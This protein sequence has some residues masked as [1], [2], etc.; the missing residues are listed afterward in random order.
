MVFSSELPDVQIIITFM[1]QPSVSKCSNT[2]Y[3]SYRPGE[4][5]F[6]KVPSFL[7]PFVKWSCILSGPA[8]CLPSVNFPPLPENKILFTQNL[9]WPG[10]LDLS[11]TQGESSPKTSQECVPVCELRSALHLEGRTSYSS[12]L[13]IF[14]SLAT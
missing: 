2:S 14:S 10:L 8:T 3:A 7:M 9:E 13:V 12:C 1:I 11:S 4:G 5:T 6:L